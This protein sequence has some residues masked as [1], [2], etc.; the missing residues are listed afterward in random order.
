[1]KM[2]R[3]RVL[4]VTIGYSLGFA[5]E[6]TVEELIVILVII[7]IMNTYIKQKL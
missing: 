6:W 7:I 5:T 3:E 1:M 4:N 2:E